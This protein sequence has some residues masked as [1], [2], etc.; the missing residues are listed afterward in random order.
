MLKFID[1]S[2][3][4]DK[5]DAASALV[6]AFPIPTSQGLLNKKEFRGFLQRI[7]RRLSADAGFEKRVFEKL[8]DQRV[9]CM[10][11]WTTADPSAVFSRWVFFRK[12]GKDW[13][14]EMLF[15]GQGGTGAE[16]LD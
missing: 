3:R 15:L 5:F 16:Q 10:E 4:A 11:D 14:L 1:E 7:G 9:V 6:A 2:I 12:M 13:K 8:D